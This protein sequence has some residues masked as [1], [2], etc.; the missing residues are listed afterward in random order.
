MYGSVSKAMSRM[1][2]SDYNPMEAMEVC[3]SPSFREVMESL[4]EV[5]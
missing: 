1:R 4:D 3:S 2:C 5:E